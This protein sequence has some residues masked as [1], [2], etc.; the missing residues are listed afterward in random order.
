VSHVG[1]L[2]S[3]RALGN[4][5]ATE[6]ASPITSSSSTRLGSVKT[7]VSVSPLGRVLVSEV[8]V[9]SLGMVLEG[10]A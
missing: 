8:S 5:E 3:F 4:G 2:S 6:V 1:K 10:V 7:L 9:S